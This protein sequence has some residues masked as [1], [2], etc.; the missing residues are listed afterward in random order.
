MKPCLMEALR[1]SIDAKILQ[2]D[3]KI[4]R[5]RASTSSS[6]S[7]IGKQIGFVRHRQA[8]WIR[9]TVIIWPTQSARRKHIPLSFSAGTST[10]SWFW[11]CLLS[12]WM[13]EKSRDEL[14]DRPKL[15]SLADPLE[16]RPPTQP[17]SRRVWS[18]PEL[19]LLDGC[20]FERVMSEEAISS[21]KSSTPSSF[22][23]DVISVVV[24]FRNVNPCF[25]SGV[26]CGDDEENW[27]G[28]PSQFF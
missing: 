19:V 20:K 12:P 26:F 17:V 13:I 10:A 5:R 22:L 25:S 16:T 24:S 18:G 6:V 11:F 4:L 28:S 2:F 21:S 23:W 27:E 14:V 1:F 9:Q 7:V 8:N 3:A 15:L